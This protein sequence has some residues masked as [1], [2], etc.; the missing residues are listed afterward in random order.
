LEAVELPIHVVEIKSLW[1]KR[2]PHPFY[3]LVMLGVL[4]VMERFQQTRRAP[5]ATTILGRAGAF[6][7]E[8][9][10]GVLPRFPR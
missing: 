8:A 3:H 9:D 5:D 1:I 6:P 2:A 4:G 7:R 10:G